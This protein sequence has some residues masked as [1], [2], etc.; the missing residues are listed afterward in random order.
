MRGQLSTSLQECVLRE[1][2]RSVEK[3]SVS[4]RDA[5]YTRYTLLSVGPEEDTFPKR[6]GLGFPD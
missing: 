3:C 4:T 5:S 1:C 6:T 2:V